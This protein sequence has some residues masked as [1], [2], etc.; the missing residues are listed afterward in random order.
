M[1]ELWNKLIG[2]MSKCEENASL[3]FLKQCV[4]IEENSSS[5]II[6]C[7]GE[8][9]A[10]YIKQ[11]ELNRIKEYINKETGQ[12]IN[13]SVTVDPQLVEENSI[14][15]EGSYKI[16]TVEDK[17][18]DENINAVIAESREK[19][20]LNSYF[21]FENFVIGTNN[22]YAFAA[23]KRVAIAPAK[24]Y[25]PLY[26]YGGVGLGKTHILQSI[27]NLFLENNPKARVAYIGGG[28]FRDEFV[29]GL[30]LK[31]PDYF[32]KKYRSLDMF[33][34]DD[35]QL[36]ETAQETSKELFELFQTLD[37]NG[38]QMVFVSDRPPKELQNIEAR[39]KSRFEKSLILP[40]EPPQ[41]ET[42]V[43]ILERKLKDF[44]TTISRDI[45][46]F[47]A[48]NI[49]TDVRKLEGGLRTYLSVRDLMNITPTV[50]QCADLGIF[51]NYFT[52]KPTLKGATVKE[53]MKIVS[54]YYDVEMSVFTSKE[55]SKYISKIRHVAIYLA[56]VY[57]GKSTIEIGLEFN[58]D[59]A[60]VIYAREKVRAD[61]KT[62]SPLSIEIEGII[63]SLS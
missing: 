12:S 28:G 46:E 41:F 23:A 4:F 62:G 51:K 18:K 21:R 24:E 58:R 16:E 6:A 25:N 44:N 52:T 63:A 17:I 22:Q 1:K 43:A 27:G 8:F 40:I 13:I 32:K 31:R 19:A 50:E 39:L 53:I 57:S 35:L 47:M 37:S 30:L 38:K 60:S 48:K 42:R 61:L 45:I 5:I 55:R 15:E 10:N 59:H 9:A 26:L 33:L 34:L 14:L 29:T 36:L 49:T 7:A 2:D 56:S 20:N 54:N 11:N 3:A